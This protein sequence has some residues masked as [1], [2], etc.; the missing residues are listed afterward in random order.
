MDKSESFMV[1]KIVLALLLFSTFLNADIYTKNC[2][3]CHK[4]LP[5]SIDKYFYKYLL[6]Y[7][8]QKAVK[9]AMVHY[10][11]KPSAKRSVMGEAFLRRFGVKKKSALSNKQLKKAI[12]IY[13]NKYKVFEKLK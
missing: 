5:V 3:Q 8:S 7:S 11:K 13:W 10:L 9:Q 12:N 1:K 6:T 2:V 4:K